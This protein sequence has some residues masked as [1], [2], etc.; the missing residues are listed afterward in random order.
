MK[1][2][3]TLLFVL[4]LTTTFAQFGIK[5]GVD[6]AT[7]K[8]KGFGS[9][10]ETGFFVG[11]TYTAAVSDKFSIQPELLYVNIKDLDFLSLPVLAKFNV[12]EKFNLLAGPSLTYFLDA[13]DDEFQFH[14]D[15]GASYDIMSNLDLNAKYSLM[16]KEEWKLNGFFV[17]L[18]Y[19]FN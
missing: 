14:L 7:V 12:A 16:L 1:K 11:A 15:F 6:F 13:E 17:G 2:L 19:K 8:V 4:S 3:L 10:S 18:G 5:A 9:S